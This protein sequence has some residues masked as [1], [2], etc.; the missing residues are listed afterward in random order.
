MVGT[1]N[2]GTKPNG[3]NVRE[4][5]IIVP[6][7]SPY[8]SQARRMTRQTLIAIIPARKLTVRAFSKRV[9]RITLPPALNSLITTH[10]RFPYSLPSSI[11]PAAPFLSLS[12]SLVHA[13]AHKF[14]LSFSLSLMCLL[15]ARGYLERAPPPLPPA[16]ALTSFTYHGFHA[17][18]H[19]ESGYDSVV[20]P[21]SASGPRSH[22]LF[23]PSSSFSVAPRRSAPF[24]SP[25]GTPHPL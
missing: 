2:C 15:P 10:S 1:R 8:V 18:S 13:H 11:S 3:D 20:R 25:S 23:L 17:G 5:I 4:Q 14:F 6:S 9:R 16:R 12:F 21:A 19:P 7:L 22:P 24:F